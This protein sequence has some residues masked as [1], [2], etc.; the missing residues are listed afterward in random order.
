MSLNLLPISPK[1]T[2]EMQII[3]SGVDGIQVSSTLASDYALPD[4]NI[5][6]WT[7]GPH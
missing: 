2:T 5:G 7:T 3:C 1:K 4:T 6:K